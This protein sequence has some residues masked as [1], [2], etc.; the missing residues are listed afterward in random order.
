MADLH[1]LPTPEDVA[2]EAAVFV[3][4]LAGK[5]V[6][7]R[8]RFT[9]ALS[10]GSTPQRLYQLL[11]SPSYARSISWSRWHV[12][13][14]D[15]RCVPPDHQ[16]SNYH[17]ARETLLDHVPVP[18]GNIH[19]I[20]GETTPENAADEYERELRHVFA[21]PDPVFDLVLLGIGEDGHT[22]SLFA[23]TDAL[24]QKTRLVVANWVPHLRAHRTT[25]TLPLINAARGVAFLVTEGSKA[26]VVRQALQPV[27]GDSPI[28][29]ALVHPVAEMV[30]WF[31]TRDASAFLKQPAT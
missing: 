14:G 4:D 11:A 20:R 21:S 25:F 9:I 27:P 15:E 24:Q 28:P 16:D 19:R 5:G 30:H 2:Q 10:G 12:F 22:A 7:K 18:A 1:I 23:G 13:W 3:T 26:E 31:L 8:G 29:A 6:K 17:M